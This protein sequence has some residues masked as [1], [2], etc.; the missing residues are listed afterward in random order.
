MRITNLGHSCLLVEM[1]DTRIL[2]DPG[3]YSP[4]A[5]EVRDLDAVLVSHQHP[6]HLDVERLPGLMTA[7]PGARLITDPDS[8]RML[9]DRGIEAQPHTRSPV[10][11]GEVTVTPEGELH[12]II[13]DEI[14]RI[15]NIGVRLDAPGEPSLFHPGDALDAEAGEVDVLAFPLAAPWSRGRDMTAFVRRFNAP[16]AVP[17]HDA[18]LSEVGRGLYLGHAKNFGGKDTHIHDLAGGGSA[19][20]TG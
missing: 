16:H 7:N 15:S 10:Q 8:A 6:D 11:V 12:A 2:I 13:H 9:R 4:G 5:A 18:L 3:V 14:P 20:F 17:I 19:E 1:A